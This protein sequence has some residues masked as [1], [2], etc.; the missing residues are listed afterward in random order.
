MKDKSELKL[1]DELWTL[2]GKM[3]DLILSNI[4]S[5]VAELEQKLSESIP[6]AN[7]VEIIEAKSIW[8]N[9]VGN[10]YVKVSDLLQAIEEL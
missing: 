10:D 7:L 1:S 2:R 6:K 9:K 4:C 8:I 5:D 3:E